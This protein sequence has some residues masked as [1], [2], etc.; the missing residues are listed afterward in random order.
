M[1]LCFVHL[2]DKSVCVTT[3]KDG[4]TVSALYPPN[5]RWYNGLIIKKSKGAS[6]WLQCVI[7]I[8]LFI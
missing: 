6:Y 8:F 5:G 3:L 1:L 4:L 2:S 7:I